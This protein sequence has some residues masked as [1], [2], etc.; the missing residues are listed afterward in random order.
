MTRI[1]KIVVGGLGTFLIIAGTLTGYIGISPWRIGTSPSSAKLAI[2]TFLVCS[3]FPYIF[4]TGLLHSAESATPAC[5]DNAPL[6]GIAAQA[7]SS[8]H[9]TRTIAAVAF[10]VIVMGFCVFFP[11]IPERYFR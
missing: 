4:A 7:E 2:L 6:G 5:E 1:L 8:S 11:L 3:M 9:V 10:A